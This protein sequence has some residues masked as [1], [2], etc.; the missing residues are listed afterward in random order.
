VPDRF[1]ASVSYRREYLKHLA[2]SV[3]LFYEGSIQGRYSYT[4]TADFNRDGQTNDLIYVPRDATEINFADVTSGGITYTA[5]QQRDL[6]FRFI[7]QDPYLRS[8][9]GRYAERNGAKMPWRNQVDVKFAQEIFHNIGGKKNTLTFTLDVFN[10]GNLLNK[11]WGIFQTPNAAGLL[12]PRN[13]TAPT[14]GTLPVN[15]VATTVGA[16]NAAGTQ[17]PYFSLATQ[18]NIPVTTSSF[19]QVNTLTSTYY[20]QFGLRYTFN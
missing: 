20:M 3:S 19:R 16:Y 9:K 1:V 5:N 14:G 18:G 10:F 15:G 8:R 13:S 17:R 2:T 11:E 12:T 7:E 6:F 4:Y